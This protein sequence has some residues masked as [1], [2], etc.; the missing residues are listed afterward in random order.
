MTFYETIINLVDYMK[1]TDTVVVVVN[2]INAALHTRKPAILD[3]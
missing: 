3:C 1:D 2:N